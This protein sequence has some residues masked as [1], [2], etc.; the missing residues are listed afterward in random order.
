MPPPACT[1]DDE[2]NSSLFPELFAFVSD[3]ESKLD[4]CMEEVFRLNLHYYCPSV[5]AVPFAYHLS[6]YDTM[7]CITNPL[8]FEDLSVVGHSD[9]PHK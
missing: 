2:V 1:N 5:A 4:A 9:K 8:S 6:L 7:G 3:L